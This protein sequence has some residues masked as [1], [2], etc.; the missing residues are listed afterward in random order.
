MAA[1]SDA[2]CGLTRPPRLEASAKK[3][4]I[5]SI[6]TKP[7]ACRTVKNTPLV[8]F[9]ILRLR[10]NPFSVSRQEGRNI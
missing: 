9:I 10:N 5:A 1:T 3:A 4:K 8:T 2:I 6:I 7:S